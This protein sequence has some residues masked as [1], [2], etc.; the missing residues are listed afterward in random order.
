MSNWDIDIFGLAVS[1]SDFDGSV[2]LKGDEF[3]ADG[4]VMDG[5]GR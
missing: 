4:E 2:G 3:F 1:A 5:F